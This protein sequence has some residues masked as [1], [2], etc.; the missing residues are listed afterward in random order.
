MADPLPAGVAILDATP[1]HLGEGAAYDPA[2]GTAWWFDILERRLFE[3]RPDTGAVRV[4]ALPLMAS[5]IA[6][7]GDGR[8]VLSAEDGL[9]LREADGRLTR[10]VAVEDDVPGTRSNDARVHPCGTFWFSTMGRAA[11]PGA[12]AIYAYRGGA[13]ARLFPDITIPNAICFTA[14]GAT[15]FFAD[16]GRGELYRVDLDPTTGLP[17]GEPALLYRHEDEAGLDGAV[18]DAAGLLWIARWGGARVDAFT[19]AGERVRSVA[20]PAR[21]PSCPAFVGAA[22]DRLLVT[23]AVENMDEAARAADPLGGQTFLVT[24]DAVG[25]PEPRIRLGEA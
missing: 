11:E 17:R 14:D 25:R 24:P 20:V 19:Q 3:A 4:H 13:V 2:T 16:T 22:L 1:C 5:A 21:Q 6:V 8:H 18:V 15:G 7:A 12:G 10:L 9:H 23:T